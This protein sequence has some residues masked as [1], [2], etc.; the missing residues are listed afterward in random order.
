MIT[1]D[2]QLVD[3]YADGK[4]IPFQPGGWKN[5]RTVEIQSTTRLLAIKGQDVANVSEMFNIVEI[6]Y[7]V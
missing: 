6:F 7:H 5:V 4:K 2:D 1:V 3:L